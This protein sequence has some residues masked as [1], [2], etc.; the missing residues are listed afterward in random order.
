M[1]ITVARFNI[2][3]RRNVWKRLISCHYLGKLERPADLETITISKRFIGSMSATSSIFIIIIS[4]FIPNFRMLNKSF[5]RN[6]ME[7]KKN[8]LEIG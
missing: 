1:Y 2:V 5:A 7:K 6:R 4:A 8:Q 3:F